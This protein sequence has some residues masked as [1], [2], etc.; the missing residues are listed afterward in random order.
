MPEMNFSRPILAIDTATHVLSLALSCNARVHEWQCEAGNRQSELI[1]P[2][3]AQLF[4][5]ASI[6]A[7]DLTAIV[8]NSGPGMFTG[9]RIGIGVAQGLAAA[10]STP[11]IGIPA[12][13]ALAFLLPDK[14]C[15][16]AAVDA[17]MGEVF[18]A[19]FDTIN[20]LRLS[21]YAVDKAEHIR[22]PEGIIMAEGI[23]NAFV[24]EAHLLPVSG[25]NGTTHARHLLALAQSKRY[26]PMLP[27][28]ANL[29]Y[30][31]NK[32]ALTIQ[33]QAEAKK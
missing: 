11:L 25:Q 22:L 10:F 19:W 28:N 26:P 4:Q 12:L 15:V 5:A 17:R 27:E 18:Y 30:V 6:G 21:D 7:H 9:L 23:G 3:I 1:L 2:A 31:R 20:H 24:D 8:Y 32:I 14:P 16:L 29:L 33:E 13:D